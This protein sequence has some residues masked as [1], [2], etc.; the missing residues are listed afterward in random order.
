MGPPWRADFADH[1]PA[2]GPISFLNY[3]NYEKTYKQ[4]NVAHHR[5]RGSPT[6]HRNGLNVGLAPRNTQ[7]GKDLSIARDHTE[8]LR[9]AVVIDEARTGWSKSADDA[10]TRWSAT[11]GAAGGEAYWLGEGARTYQIG[12]PYRN[13]FGVTVGAV[14]LVRQGQHRSG[15]LG[16][17]AH[18]ARRLAR[19]AALLSLLALAGCGGSRAASNTT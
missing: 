16:D 2:I 6:G 9:F 4:L 11:P 10:G 12:M 17:A 15:R 3:Y 19:A 8:G 5:W 18:P 13:S 1:C 7:L 14:V